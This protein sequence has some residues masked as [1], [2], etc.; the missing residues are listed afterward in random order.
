MITFADA[1]NFNAPGF[2]IFT[3]NSLFPQE[4]GDYKILL[5][6]DKAAGGSAAR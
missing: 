1:G 4:V 3:D 5:V 2:K 6:G